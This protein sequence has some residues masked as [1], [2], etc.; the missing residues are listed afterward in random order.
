MYIKSKLFRLHGCPFACKD[1]VIE[2]LAIDQPDGKPSRLYLTRETLHTAIFAW[3]K[4]LSQYDKQKTE[5]LNELATFTNLINR[6]E[7]IGYKINKVVYRGYTAGDTLQVMHDNAI[8]A[9]T[10]LKLE[11]ETEEQAQEL[12]DL[13]LMREAERAEKEQQVQKQQAEHEIQMAKLK[14]DE[15]LRNQKAEHE[16]ALA[17]QKNRNELDLE[18]VKAKNAQQ[19]EYLKAMEAMQIDLTQYLVAQ[20]Q[21]PDKLIRIAGDNQPQLHLHNN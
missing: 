10:Q 4:L 13:K 16:N 8:E 1:G 11:A 12:A 19:V 14:H 2:W 7:R 21:N 20:Y 18:N 15:M 5:Q 3:N 6:A 9:R 17:A